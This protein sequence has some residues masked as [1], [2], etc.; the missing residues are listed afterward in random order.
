[1]AAEISSEKKALLECVVGALADTQGMSA[2]ALGGSHARGTHIA[3]S[4][5]DIGL[6]YR[7]ASPFA[8]SDIRRVAVSLS[9]TGRPTVTELYEWGPFVNGGAWIDNRTSKID[10]LYRNLDQLDR[11]VRDAQAGRW[12]HHF[13]QQ[14]P[15][16]FRSVTTLGEIFY[17]RPLADPA[18]VL[19]DLKS[20]VAVFP[21]ALKQ[22][23]VQSTLWL[24]EFSFMIAETFARDGDVPNTVACM[25]RIHHYLEHALFALN[26]TYLVNE[27]RVARVIQGFG[28]CP[29]DF[30][31]KATAILGHA[32]TS[33]KTLCESLEALKAVWRD[34]VGLAGE[35]YRS[36]FS[37]A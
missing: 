18:G 10:F 22:H 35:G 27:K 31:A 25:T 5:L 23:V 2:I 33:T 12:E 7:E 29:T 11:V 17:C 9:A 3:E 26:D 1:M 4:D 36:R 16:G 14:P 34:V 21:P 24:A 6:Y 13:D 19:A 28:V 37:V 30:Y 32:G 15:F 8:I 20:R